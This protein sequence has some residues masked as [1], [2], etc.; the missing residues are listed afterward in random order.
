MAVD[1][2]TISSPAGDFTNGCVGTRG[3]QLLQTGIDVRRSQRSLLEKSFPDA[4]ALLSPVKIEFK[5]D[6]RRALQKVFSWGCTTDS[7]PNLERCGEVPPVALDEARYGLTHHGGAAVA[8]VARSAAASQLYISFTARTRSRVVAP[9]ALLH[10]SSCL[11]CKTTSSRCSCVPG[12]SGCSRCIESGGLHRLSTACEEAAPREATISR[13]RVQVN[14]AMEVGFVF[15]L[16]CGSGRSLA[17]PLTS[18]LLSTI[19]SSI[20]GW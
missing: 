7:S 3:R 4:S 10:C 16:R 18:V 12:R 6:E 1:H 15:C 9:A 20:G 14:S 2:C 19:V 8:G 5:P 11:A 17:S 13:I